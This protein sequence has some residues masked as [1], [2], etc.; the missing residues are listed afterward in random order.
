MSNDNHRKDNM[1]ALQEMVKAC[2][3]IITKQAIKFELN[4]S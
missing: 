3:S 1:E 2:M 4:V